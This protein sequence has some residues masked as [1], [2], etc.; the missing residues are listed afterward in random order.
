MRRHKRTERR[1]LISSALANLDEDRRIE[2]AEVEAENTQIREDM[3]HVFDILREDE[4]EE[5]FSRY[6]LESPYDNFD[7]DPYDFMEYDRHEEEDERRFY[8]DAPGFADW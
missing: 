1:R 2:A 8:G 3:A 6:G 4:R 7:H 5:N